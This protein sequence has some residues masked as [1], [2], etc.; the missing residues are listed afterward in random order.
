MVPPNRAGI[1]ILL[2]FVGAGFGV[3]RS[4]KVHFPNTEY[5]TPNPV[6]S[7]QLQGCA[8]LRSVVHRH[9]SPTT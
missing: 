7:C 3:G 6:F 8:P 5:R 9:G 1:P 4:G 2:L